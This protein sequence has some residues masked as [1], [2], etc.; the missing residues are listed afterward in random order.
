MRLAIKEVTIPTI[1]RYFSLLKLKNQESNRINKYTP[2]VTKVEEWTKDETGVGAAIAA[3]NHA[4][5]GTWA[6]LVKVAKTNTQIHIF[7][8][9]CSLVDPI[10][11]FKFVIKTAILN[12]IRISPNRLVIAV[13]NPEL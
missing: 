4:E 2:A 13:I 12:I 7:L 8:L 11:Q 10:L 5:K 3:G 9:K 6:L 1:A